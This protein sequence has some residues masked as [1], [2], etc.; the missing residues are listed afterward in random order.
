M[1]RT[2]ACRPRPPDA[3]ARPARAEGHVAVVRRRAHDGRRPGAGAVLAHVVPGAAV[4]VVAAGT[5]LLGRVRADA[6]R[7]V[8]GAGDVTLIGRGT[9]DGVR[10]AAPS[11]LARVGLRAGVPVVAGAAVGA[12]RAGAHAGRGIAGAR[13]VTLI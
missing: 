6:R 9:G 4:A 11:G 10:P 13:D 1:P 2:E 3:A 8:A 12:D 7:G 5:I